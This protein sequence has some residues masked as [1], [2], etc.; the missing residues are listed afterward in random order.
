MLHPLVHEETM[1]LACCLLVASPTPGAQAPPFHP[2]VRV[3]AGVKPLRVD[4]CG[5]AAP[6]WGDVDNDG[7]PELIVGQFAY[8]WMRAYRHVGGGAFASGKVVQAN[9]QNAVVPDIA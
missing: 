8:A 6:A 2:P 4:E 5:H 3:S 9:G 1:L 7:K